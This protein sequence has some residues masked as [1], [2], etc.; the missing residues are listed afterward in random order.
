MWS[1]RCKINCAIVKAGL[2]QPRWAMRSAS[3]MPDVLIATNV[4]PDN[5]KDTFLKVV[6]LQNRVHSA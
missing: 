3:A 1:R 6:L 4:M 2:Y 5:T